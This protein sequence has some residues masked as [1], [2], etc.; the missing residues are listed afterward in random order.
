[1][2]NQVVLQASGLC[3]KFPGVQALDHVDFELKAG[4]VHVLVGENGAGKST[5]VNLL[6]G[7]YSKDEGTIRLRG[8]QVDI[9]NPAHASKL[10]IAII[11]QELNLLPYL[12][13]GQN[14][15]LG[16]EPIKPSGMINWRVLYQKAKELCSELEID[17][18]VYKTV[19][20]L[21]IAKQ[22]LVEI[23]KALSTNAEI[24]IMDEPSAVLTQKELT[25]LFKLIKR[26]KEKGVAIVYISHRI[27]EIWEIGDRIT[28]MRDGRKITTVPMSEIDA[29]QL[30]S[31]MIGREPKAK[32]GKRKKKTSETLM[33]V[34]L[35]IP[36][37]VKE[38]SFELRKG[39]I[40]GVFGLAGSGRVEILN[41]LFG[42][43]KNAKGTITYA[44]KQ[45]S[46]RNPRVAKKLGI[47]YLTAD[48]KQEGLVLQMSVKDNICMVNPATIAL[49]FISEKKKTETARNFIK[50]FNI[51]CSHLE[52]RV[53]SLSGGNQQKVVLSK[54][55]NC[56]PQI[57]LMDEPT[58]GID[59]GAK[60]EVR[61][62]IDK[63]VDQGMS[64]IL[65]SSE[66]PEIFEM[67]DRILVTYCGEIVAEIP[68]DQA[69]HDEVLLYAMSGGV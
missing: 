24:I 11:H 31:L 5:L 22:Q 32:T 63:L 10:G 26:L 57:L 64:V 62:L 54:W 13:V 9:R 43:E 20:E 19:N 7:V 56:Q 16:R 29:K 65:S 42:L 12:T 41:A 27:E 53:V 17:L 50:R 59:V 25:V 2:H 46:I 36:P 23:M 68:A 14:I 67:S 8:K 66:L 30:V 45:V 44:G 48:R 3:K 39:E 21:P 58:R 60:E 1:M 4:E 35:Q 51:R 15:F 28:V 18:D 55:L 40:L 38:V 33:R 52:Q 47:G 49:G 69:K 37:M 61:E 6:T 34:H